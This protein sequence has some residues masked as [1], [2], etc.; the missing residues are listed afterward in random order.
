MA[1]IGFK[2]FRF[3]AEFMYCFLLFFTDG[4]VIKPLPCN[5]SIT[6]H[7]ML[8]WIA[9]PV[10]TTPSYDSFLAVLATLVIYPSCVT[11]AF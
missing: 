5:H 3:I 10:T 7:S 2:M 8:F 4:N 11:A 6:E 1:L 9:E